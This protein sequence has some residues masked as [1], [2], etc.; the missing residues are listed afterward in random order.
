M[1]NLSEELMKTKKQLD[2]V[3]AKLGYAD[4]NSKA[5]EEKLKNSTSGQKEAEGRIEELMKELE[6]AKLAREDAKQAEE[7]AIQGKDDAEKQCHDVT[8]ALGSL[9]KNLQQEKE[10]N[11][12]MQSEIEQR[13]SMSQHE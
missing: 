12:T 6:C 10:R 5:F 7:E 8:S 3:T 13:A 9:E 2:R 4:Q 11:D 1:E